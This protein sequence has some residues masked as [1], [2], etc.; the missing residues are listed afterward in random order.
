MPPLPWTSFS[1]PF[2]AEA[3]SSR[4]KLRKAYVTE[5][6][7]SEAQVA[8]A[9]GSVWLLG[10]DFGQQPRCA[11]VGRERA[12]PRDTDQ[13]VVRWQMPD[14]QETRAERSQ[15]YFRASSLRSRM[16]SRPVIGIA[17][18]TRLKP[19]PS[20]CDQAEPT[21]ANV[22]RMSCGVKYGIPCSRFGASFAASPACPVTTQ[23]TCSAC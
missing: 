12:S 15:D 13:V 5:F 4:F 10:V 8:Q 9:E 16:T 18:S 2:S 22:R 3:P 17:D 11:S 14:C 21:V 23:S 20:G 19:F 1:P 6:G 7:T